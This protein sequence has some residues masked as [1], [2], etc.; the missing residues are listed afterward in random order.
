MIK[1]TKQAMLEDK[2]SE[3]WAFVNGNIDDVDGRTAFECSKTGDKTANKV[4]FSRVLAN[5]RYHF[6]SK[7]NINI[8]IAKK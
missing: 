8:L 1:Q 5:L 3:M 7:Q 2:N 4:V 6:Y